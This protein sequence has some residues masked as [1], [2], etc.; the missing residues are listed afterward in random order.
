M[1]VPTGFPR[2]WCCRRLPRATRGPC[3]DIH[4]P[5]ESLRN[6]A[7]P[8][9]L[10]R[11]WIRRAQYAARLARSSAMHGNAELPLEAFLGLA[12]YR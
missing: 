4:V 2:W 6:R 5:E 3:P 1:S 10:Q 12:C 11:D 7:A 9:G 8:Q